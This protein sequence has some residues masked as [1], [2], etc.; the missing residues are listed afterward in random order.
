VYDAVPVALEIGAQAARHYGALA[1]FGFRRLGRVFRQHLVF[2][3][4]VFLTEA[5][6]LIFH[7]LIFKHISSNSCTIRA[8]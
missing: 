6:R 3:L 4:F 8:A 5:G 2:A 1:A 7:T